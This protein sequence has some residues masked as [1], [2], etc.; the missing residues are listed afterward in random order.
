MAAASKLLQSGGAAAA[1]LLAASEEGDIAVSAAVAAGVL[2][3]TVHVVAFTDEEGVRFQSTFLGSR[4]L[5]R[6]TWPRW[7]M[8]C[9]PDEVITQL[10]S[11][12]FVFCRQ[13]R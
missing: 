5:V 4:A 13:G 7:A 12:L 9:P 11:N 2:R 10:S 3:R 6:E 1:A 8:A